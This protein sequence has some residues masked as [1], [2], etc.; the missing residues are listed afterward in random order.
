MVPATSLALSIPLRYRPLE[1][2]GIWFV[3]TW[4]VAVVAV[5]AGATRRG[6]VAGTGVDVTSVGHG[7]PLV[8]GR[9][10]VI[11]VSSHYYMREGR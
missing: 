7:F 3:S 8:S 4:A 2:K 9:G 1:N 6:E 10:V 5:H 11:D